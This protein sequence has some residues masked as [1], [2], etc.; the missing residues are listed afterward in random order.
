MRRSWFAVGCVVVTA[1]GGQHA[2]ARAASPGATEAADTRQPAGPALVAVDPAP[3]E[4][5]ASAEPS[6]RARPRAEPPWLGA[7]TASALSLTRSS[8][9]RVAVWID[10][11][12]ARPPEHVPTAT[13]L[14]ID[15]SGSMQGD[16]IAHARQ[17]ARALARAMHDGDVVS[18]IAF[19]T[20]VRE[21]VPPTL[22]DDRSRGEVERAIGGLRAAGD[23]NLHDGL[24]T[25]VWYASRAPATHPLRRVVLVS[26]GRATVGPSSP[27]ALGLLAEDGMARGTQVTALGVGLDYDELTLNEIAVRS[28][29]RFYHLEHSTSF[30]SVV[31]EELRVLE[32][33]IAADAY[34]ELV[35]A[36]GVH[37]EGVI[38]A[39]A[40]RSG[41]GWRVPLGALYAGQSR[42]LSVRVRLPERGPGVVQPVL[43][44]RLHFTD[45]TDGALPRVQEVAV[46]TVTTDDAA[47]VAARRVPRAESVLATQDAAEWAATAAARAGSGDLE[48]AQRELERAEH[49]LREQAS[50]TDDAVER[51]RLERRASTMGKARKSA[52]A[53]AAAPA[54]DRPRASR[55]SALDANASSMELQGY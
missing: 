33:T 54:A 48:A 24:R 43:S 3:A 32:R 20:T 1:C 9:Q 47:A 14:V 18:V 7:S 16:K 55:A 15:T 30:A 42:E 35:P 17:A 25:A 22:L 10:V 36:P 46:R 11:P 12:D 27:T 37:V 5:G 40:Q 28:S 38:G 53:A 41:A 49:R 6:A 44:A 13:A 45:L 31:T 39:R 21:I 51:E 52:A 8:D 19:D 2:G 4:P 26:D 23:T 34:V 50:A 29:G